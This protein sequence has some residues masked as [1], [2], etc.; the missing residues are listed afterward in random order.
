MV[1]DGVPL[2]SL[3]QR[4]RSAFM[5]LREELIHMHGD[6]LVAL[7]GYGAAVSPEPPA[8]LGDL[9]THGVLA[10]PPSPETSAQMDEVRQHIDAEHGVELDSW[11]ILLDDARGTALPAHLLNP[12]LVDASWALHR[13]H[14]LAGRFV[15]LHGASPGEIVR[16]PDWEEVEAGLNCELRDAEQGLIRDRSHPFA[17]YA[18][19]NC[20]RVA[21]SLETRDAAVTKRESARWALGALPERWHEAIRAA[22]RWYDREEAPGDDRVLRDACRSLASYVRAMFPP[23]A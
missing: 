16:R 18:V 12:S 6:D 20:C 3:G 7:W 10:R 15:L 11:Y 17:S 13:C 9:D 14:W 22:V 21:F 23:T 19:L 2:S 4:V 1:M 5:H 8:R